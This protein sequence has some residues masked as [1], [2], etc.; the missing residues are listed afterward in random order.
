MPWSNQSGGGGWKGGGNGPWGQ[1]PR[2]PKGGNEPP[3][4]EDLLRRGQD[5]IRQMMP[6]GGGSGRPGEPASMLAALP[7]V[8]LV[9]F[10]FWLYESIYVV[11]PDEVGIE[12]RFGKVKPE[13]NEP[14][15]HFALWPIETVEKPTLLRENQEIIGGTSSISGGDSIMLSA[16]QNLVNVEFS[17]LWRIADPVKFLFKVD[18]QPNLVR[19]VSESVMREVV[20]RTRADEFRTTGREAAQAAVRAKVQETLDA[21][22]A[23]ITVT[24]VNVTKAEPPA[25]VMDAFGEVQRAQQDQ[26]KFKQDAQAYANKRQGDARGEAS[27]IREAALGYRDQV[28]ADATGAAQR[29]NSVYEQYVKAPEITRERIYIE[30]MQDILSRTDKVLL[31]SNAANGGVLPYLPLPD[32]KRSAPA[33]TTEGGQ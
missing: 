29:F 27:Q 16:D 28:I 4:L 13:I 24:A 25:Q 10:G 3:D 30:T 6:G 11:Q 15:V 19:V 22:N 8:A 21:Y 20:G 12:L 31:D 14:G 2:N 23:G 32:I 9:V 33:T 17:V 26:D 1:P 5:K 18:D 7:L